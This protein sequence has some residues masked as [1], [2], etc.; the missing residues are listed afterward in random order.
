MIVSSSEALSLLQALILE[1]DAAP[2]IESAIRTVVEAIYHQCQ[3]SYGEA[4]QLDE[5]TQT[6][7]QTAAYWPTEP[8]AT[9]NE[10]ILR[11]KRFGEVSQTFSFELGSGIPGRIWNSGQYEWHADVSTESHEIFIRNQ[12][13]AAYQMRTAFGIPL[14]ADSQPKAVLVFFSRQAMPEVPEI[15]TVIESIICYASR[16]IDLRQ[17]QA[18][19]EDSEARLLAFLDRSPAIAF[20]KDTAGRYAYANSQLV[21]CSE[22][23]SIEEVIGKTDFDCFDAEVATAF[24]ENDEQVLSTQQSQLFVEVTPT[25]DGFG[26]HSQVVKFPFTDRN[27]QQFLG[28]IVVDITQQKRLEKQ[29]EAE[30][31]QQQQS[32]QVIQYKLTTAQA[33]AAAKSQFFAMMGHEIRTPVNA[34][35]G[36]TDLLVDTPLTAEQQELVQGI[37][38][39]SETLLRVIND[40]LDFSKLESGKVELEAGRL[41]LEECLQQI[42]SLFSRQAEASGVTLTVQLEKTS[43]PTCFTGDITRL[44]Q[45]LSNLVSN[46]LKF[47]R[48]GEISIQMQVGLPVEDETSKDCP[49]TYEVICTVSDTGMGIPSDK[50][51]RLFQPFT[52]TDA[53]ITRQYGGTGLGLSIV[54]QLVEL[55]GGQISVTSEVGQGTTFQFSLRL[56]PYH[57]ADQQTAKPTVERTPRIL[58]VEDMRMNQKIVL[59]MLETCNYRADVVSN[60]KEAISHLKKNHYDL[61]LMAIEMHQMGGIEATQSIRNIHPIQQPYV[62]ALADFDADKA[63]EWYISN[64]MNDVLRKPFRR[65]DWLAVLQRYQKYQQAA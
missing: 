43:L 53:S 35:V 33:T 60:G 56:A 22:Q 57:L 41:D 46:A 23:S 13:A 39:G 19:L 32:N 10:S 59:K 7:Q 18:T 21:N 58:L 51:H 45:V 42:L 44:R 54:K 9:C 25:V 26:T 31:Q 12:V 61:V 36:M 47:T 50:V 52:Q 28:G 65:V 3:W 17:R 16:L 63:T 15:V 1:L 55:M 64:G 30:K 49:Q 14:F 24:R 37:Q 38:L 8:L 62:I 40:I 27:G 48:A 29:L 20:I 4:W 6:L 5:Q 11:I 34:V 2:D